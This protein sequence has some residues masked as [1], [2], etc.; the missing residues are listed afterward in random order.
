MNTTGKVKDEQRENPGG[1]PPPRRPHGLGVPGFGMY[2]GSVVE[3]RAPTS[4]RHPASVRDRREADRKIPALYETFLYSR[5][6]SALRPGL[7]LSRPSPQ[8]TRRPSHHPRHPVPGPMALPPPTSVARFHPLARP[9][10][11]PRGQRLETTG[12]NLAVAM[13]PTLPALPASTPD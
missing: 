9:T 8:R 12:P 6:F 4:L 7:C 11:T 13:R 3:A 10:Q 1:R 5:T 2:K